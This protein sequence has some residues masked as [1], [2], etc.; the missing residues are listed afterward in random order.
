MANGQLWGAT[1][2]ERGSP[3]TFPT[4]GRKAEASTTHIPGGNKNVI[5]SSGLSAD[6]LSLGIRCS[7]AELVAL[8]AKV[9]TTGTLV[10]AW[11]N[12]SAYLEEIDGPAEVLAS[13]KYFVTL[14]LIG[15]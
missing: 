11:G 15:R 5:Q 3:P 4:W 8:Y 9:D 7:A 2:K 10:M 13:G 14:K 12:R 6:R 1:F